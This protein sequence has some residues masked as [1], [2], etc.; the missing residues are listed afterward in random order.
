MSSMLFLAAGSAVAL[1][2]AIVALVAP[3]TPRGPSQPVVPV[4]SHHRSRFGPKPRDPGPIP[5]NV[6]DDVVAAG[7]NT[8]ASED[9]AC[10]P[11]PPALSGGPAVSTGSPSSAMLS[12]LPILRRPATAADQLPGGLLSRGRRT[13]AF[14]AG[15]VYVR[16]VRLA[17]VAEG[18]SFYLVPAG[19]L[20]RPPLSAAVAGRC[21]RLEVAALRAS[22]PSVPPSERAATR[23]YGDANYALGRYNEETSSVHEG[24]FLV[25]TRNNAIGIDGGQ[26]PSTIRQSGMLGGGGGG[27][28]P[29]PIVM[30]GIVPPGVATVT[31]TFPAARHGTQSLPALHATGDVVNDVF[32]I[33]IPSLFERGA[34]PATAIWRSASG[35]I[36]KTVNERPFHP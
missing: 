23:R 9:R 25:T 17:R 15:E 36:I 4:T 18:G 12:T 16:H 3:G 31:L 10:G 22:L 24:V 1:G 11:R 19:R 14:Q 2:V 13:F 33:P 28:P 20:G 21:Y 8:A 30:D 34:W 27:T 6:D 29:S 35:T 32:V 7:W 5:R 26:S